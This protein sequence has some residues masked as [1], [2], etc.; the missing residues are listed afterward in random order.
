MEE[1]RGSSKGVLLQ[2]CAFIYMNF[3]SLCSILFNMENEQVNKLTDRNLYIFVTLTSDLPY[4]QRQ[5]GIM[6]DKE[7]II[8]YILLTQ[9]IPL[10][11]NFAS[12]TDYAKVGQTLDTIYG[13]FRTCWEY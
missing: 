13:R 4:T 5:R 1:K 2:K 11:D 12:R 6:V 10:R 8:I 9:K 3:C 7:Y